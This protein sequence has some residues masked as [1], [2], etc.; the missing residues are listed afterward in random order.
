LTRNGQP[1]EGSGTAFSEQPGFTTLS[2]FL[3]VPFGE[4]VSSDLQ[5]QLPQVTSTNE[6]GLHQYSLTI[7]KQAGTLPE[8]VSITVTLPDDASFIESDIKPDIINNKTITF[9][10]ILN[11]DKTIT[12]SYQ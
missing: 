4:K 8:P 1:I 12:L 10:I 9:D 3:L 7:R 6:D 2:N 5:Y 11:A